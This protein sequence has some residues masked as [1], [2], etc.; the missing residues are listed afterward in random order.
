MPSI[1]TI[2]VIGAGQMGGGIAQLCAQSGFPVVLLDVGDEI[3]NTAITRISGRLEGRVAKGR[4]GEAEAAA[5]FARISIGTDPSIID[6]ADL[7]IEAA[8]E[9]EAVKRAVFAALAA[10]LQPAT[11]IVTTTSSLSVTN[12]A[13]ATDRPSKFMGMHFLNPALAVPLVELVRGLA[14]DEETFAAIRGLARQLGKTTVVAE[15]VP[16][17]LVNRTLLVMI[18]EAVTT[19]H[20]GIGTVRSIDAALTLGAGHSMGPLELADLI[21]LDTCLIGLQALYEKLAHGKYRPCPLL[22]KHVEAG[23]LGRKTGRGFYD[24]S[25]SLGSPAQRFPI[26]WSGGEQPGPVAGDL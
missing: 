1:R 12:L 11:L 10:H 20:K 23:W 18:N 21:G 19:L 3:L 2:A 24:Y 9:S 14:T 5:A 8:T 4:M 16:A 7:V 22:V 25:K 17:F 6:G 15:D 13:A 26:P